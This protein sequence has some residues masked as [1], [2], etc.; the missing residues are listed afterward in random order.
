MIF[1]KIGEIQAGKCFLNRDGCMQDFFRDYLEK[2]GKLEEEHKC[3]WKITEL[4][5]TM[6]VQRVVLG[7]N[8][9]LVPISMLDQ[10]PDGYLV[11]ENVLLVR[12]KLRWETI[13][14]FFPSAGAYDLLRND[15]VLELIRPRKKLKRFGVYFD[16][17]EKRLHYINEV[18]LTLDELMYDWEGWEEILR[19][20]PSLVSL[21]STLG[22]STLSLSK[23][24]FSITKIDENPKLTSLA[25]AVKEICIPR[26]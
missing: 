6:T 3:L 12:L 4:D 20:Y 24:N 21:S 22:L 2:A 26:K 13:P 19:G 10:I 25:E 15:K 1:R 23:N 5:G 16:K 14:L 17:K 8:P 9:F 7:N 11:Q 18:L